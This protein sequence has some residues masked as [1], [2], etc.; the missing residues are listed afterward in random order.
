MKILIEISI[1]VLTFIV[2]FYFNSISEISN[3]IFYLYF[4]LIAIDLKNTK[5]ITFLQVWVFSFIF[6]I[7]SEMLLLDNDISTEL[8]LATARFLITAN[9]TVIIGYLLNIKKPSIQHNIKI[10][11][12]NL[13]QIKNDR[14]YL[15]LIILFEII[16]II[17][18]LPNA[19]SSFYTGRNTN[20][21]ST[22]ESSMAFS[23]ILSSMGMIL[24]AITAFYIKIKN[25]K[26]IYAILLTSPIFLILF[27]NGTRFP[28]LFSTVGLLSVCGLIRFH[29]LK[30]KYITILAL[31]A[32]IL[33]Q[34]TSIMKDFR[35]RGVRNKSEVELTVDKKKYFSSEVAK[36]MSPEGIF[37]MS[38]LMLKYFEFN[39]HTLGVSSGFILYFWIPRTIWPE[40]PTMI[41]Y[42]LLRT[43]RSGF[44]IGNNSSFGFAG[45]LY[46]DFGLFSLI[47]LLILGMVIKKI[48]RGWNTII[49][50]PLSY[51]IIIYSMLLPYLFF[52][53]RSPVTSSTMFI[54]MLILYK[55]FKLLIKS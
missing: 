13:I 18:F 38:R 45:E 47:F 52:F 14:L 16:Y 31:S 32:I 15:V 33:I 40:K 12:S 53:V 8:D 50:G 36:E 37:D 25:R 42:W 1:I 9:N 48:E 34:L 11:N 49:K 20:I 30:L 10:A 4:I 19:L 41:G 54:G 35:V 5:S 44:S 27:L 22:S 26:T 51:Q 3:A 23:T 7:N 2:A 46:S 39:P 17:Y 55:I 24:P 28:L 6:I 43:D 21:I 29:N